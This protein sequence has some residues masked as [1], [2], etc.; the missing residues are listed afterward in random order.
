MRVRRW[1]VSSLVAAAAVLACS[2]M[3]LGSLPYFLGGQDP[4]DPPAL[5]KLAS[6]DKDKEVKVAILIYGGMET[7]PEFHTAD[8]DLSR[9]IV[10]KMGEAAK[11]NGEK[12]K[13]VSATKVDSFKSTHLNWRTMEKDEIGRTLDAD[14]VV[15]VEINQLSMYKK[16]SAN[17]LYQGQAQLTVNL[18]DVN[19]PDD[20]PESKDL[21][22]TY[23]NE[24]LD[25]VPVDDKAPAVFLGE[26]YDK[27]ATQVAW[28]FTAHPTSDNYPLEQ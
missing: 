23:P 5:K 20:P 25:S 14:Y 2:C 16:G 6:E 18:I 9:R 24:T 28:Q 19:N 17:L 27:I 12:L 13:M 8:R 1:L 22:I 21:T 7:R 4:T 10:K 11:T 26:F 3:P 15:Y